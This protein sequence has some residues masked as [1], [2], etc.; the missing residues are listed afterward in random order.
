MERDYS[1][2]Q[3]LKTLARHQVALSPLPE[4]SSGKPFYNLTEG[5]TYKARHSLIRHFSHAARQYLFRAFSALTK[6]PFVNLGRWPR[7]SHY[8]PLA[9]KER[10]QKN[11]TASR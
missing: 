6:I 3:V 10:L 4:L 8:A 7:L 1:S 11:L 9:L 2:A 5:Q